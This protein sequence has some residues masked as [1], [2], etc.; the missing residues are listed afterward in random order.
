MTWQKTWNMITFSNAIWGLCNL[1]KQKR[2]CNSDCQ[3]Y[4][5]GKMCIKMLPWKA[6][7]KNCF[8]CSVWFSEIQKMSKITCINSTVKNRP[9]DK[10]QLVWSK[11]STTKWCM[12]KW[13]WRGDLLIC[14]EK[15]MSVLVD[16]KM[17]FSNLF[18]LMTL[19]EKH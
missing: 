18:C 16:L 15:S 5:T 6:T 19:L 4:F 2:I 8:H 1:I 11:L 14:R 12:L 13:D 9:N 3:S 10:L 17:I 7:Q